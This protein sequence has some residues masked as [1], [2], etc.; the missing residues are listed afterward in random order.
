MACNDFMTIFILPFKYFRFEEN[1]GAWHEGVVTAKDAADTLVK[2]NPGGSKYTGWT[3]S[4]YQ[5]DSP[6]NYAEFNY[7][8][9]HV[10]DTIF[11]KDKGGE[12]SLP[13][14]A[15]ERNVN[16]N[17][18]GRNQ[19]MQFLTRGDYYEMTVR[20]YVE[21][22]DLNEAVKK[23]V[24]RTIS[25]RVNSID[26]HLYDNQIGMLTITTEMKPGDEVSYDD[27]LRYNDVARRVYPPFLSERDNGII[28]KSY[29]TG[30]LKSEKKL[31]PSSVVLSHASD[32]KKD[33]PEDF[34]S[35]RLPDDFP[36][37]SDVVKGLLKP[38]ECNN[39]D[40]KKYSSNIYYT[41]ATDDRMF[42]VSY[43]RDD[44]R[45]SIMQSAGSSYP[46][47]T[48]E[49][50]YRFIFVDGGDAS[51]QND[52]MMKDLI[53]SHTYARWA[54]YGTFFGMS[55]Y[56]FVVLCGTD[57]Y[58]GFHNIL[59]QHMKSMYYQIALMGLF[60]RCMLIKLAEDVDRLSER[61]QKE[62]IKVLAKESSNLR[63]DYIS[64][65]NKYWHVEVTPQEQG[66]EM[67]SQFMS[68]L[69]LDR[70]YDEV[71][72]E[73]EELEE[74]VDN[75]IE[76]DTNQL[77]F[78]TNNEVARITRYGLPLML[79]ALVFSVWQTLNGATS[80]YVEPI[81]CFVPGWFF[82]FL[83]LAAAAIAFVLIWCLLVWY[84]KRTRDKNK[85]DKDKNRTRICQRR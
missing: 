18:A 64:F 6:E 15:G 40:A 79:I 26:L 49:D 25:V 20:F 60:Q 1:G 11:M 7:F 58:G 13:N 83:Q 56:S 24:T 23:T 57:Q 66:I 59:K 67:Y 72:R 70:L 73:I 38:L 5:I 71:H 84:M 63:R 44:V 77:G 22:N 27:F 81:K 30:P 45:S 3:R 54:N 43:C 80:Y 46:Y 51:V 17:V 50:W 8:H 21:Q 82:V 28:C 55:R 37:L 69:A 32:E 9:R 65:I 19:G 68:I 75:K 34:P 47:K 61:L 36:Y 48:S 10:H 53:K 16:R 52:E 12:G 33:I 31:L 42:I 2:A 76:F 29:Q 14:A 35:L 85:T 41:P 74:Y 39:R 78:E 62:D 4:Y